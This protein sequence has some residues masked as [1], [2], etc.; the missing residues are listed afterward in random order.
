MVIALYS[1]IVFY[2]FIESGK[3]AVG[4]LKVLSLFVVFFAAYIAATN[5]TGDDYLNYL[6]K[7]RDLD[8]GK[9]RLISGYME[10]GFQLAMVGA[11]IIGLDFTSFLLIYESIILFLIYAIVI[12]SGASFGLFFLLYFPKYFIKGNMSQIRATF[13]YGFV[14]WLLYWAVCGRRL[15]YYTM[16]FVGAAFHASGLIFIPF[17]K[18]LRRKYSRLQLAALIAISYLLGLFLPSLL[19]RL[20]EFGLLGRA[21]HYLA[22]GRAK[23]PLFGI[24]VIRRI[25][26]IVIMLGLKDKIAKRAQ[27]G[28]SLVNLYALSVSAY[29]LFIGIRI[30]A[31]RFSAIFGIAEIMLF[32]MALRTFRKEERALVFVL[33]AI[34]AFVDL[35]LRG[36]PQYV[37]VWQ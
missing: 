3:R 5:T 28:Q 34:Y 11:K 29:F 4:K 8:S 10:P 19:D 24:E 14:L 27:L 37:G 2:A 23:I 20:P 1:I 33:I 25:V 31:E 17:R 15:R 30:W 9:G 21:L 26:T 35:F 6:Y 32:A 7:Y 22:D 36:V 18:V 16:I 12:K 13:I